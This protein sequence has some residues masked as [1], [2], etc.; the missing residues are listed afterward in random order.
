V[1]P[2]SRSYITNRVALK[3]DTI[4]SQAKKRKAAEAIVSSNPSKK[5]NKGV[6][7]AAGNAA[8]PTPLTMGMD[9]DD[10]YMSGMSSGDDML[11]EGSDNEDGSADGK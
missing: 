10:E 5:P 3:V 11:E 2:K 9:T 7:S 6:A 1:I 4:S 8:P